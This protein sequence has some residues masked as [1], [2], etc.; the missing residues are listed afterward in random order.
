MRSIGALALFLLASMACRAGTAAAPP[1]PQLQIFNGSEEEI[2][3]L[4]LAPDG[5]R[6]DNGTVAPG[7]S[8]I[9]STTLGHRF[10]IQGRSTQTQRM[11]TAEVPVQAYRFP[12]LP[13]TLPDD[14]RVM[15]PPPEMALPPFYTQCLSARGFPIVASASVS[16]YALKEVGYLAN[17]MLD[18]RPDVRQAMIRSGA[19]MCII[20][21]SEFTTDL[22]ESAR[23]TRP[24]GYEPLS[25]KEYWDAR[26]RGT[27]GSRTDP[28]CTCAE[29]NVLG[30]PGDP[31]SQECIVIHEFAHNIHLRGLINVDP[32]FDDRLK[33]TYERAMARGLWRGKYASVNHHEYFAEGVQSWF[34]NNREN[35]HDHN[36][37]NTR[38]ELEAYDPGLADICGDV[39]GETMIQYTKPAT[40]VRDHLAGYDPAKVPTF[41]WPE[42][43]KNARKVIAEVVRKRS[44]AAESAAPPPEE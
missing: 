24:R 6:H 3:V 34:D 36:H 22:P 29:E 10:F 39:F 16:P 35:D 30:Y 11:V 23:L 19:R 32:T 44:A 41:T 12:A 27:G 8:R 13:V 31:Y 17:Q 42:R 7:A 18:H 33:T 25:D 43:L 37:V 2:Q 38:T 9:I 26:A 5:S 14:G 4:W 21:H 15:P 1:R 20:G 40:R 28:I